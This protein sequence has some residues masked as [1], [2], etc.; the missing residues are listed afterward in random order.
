[1]TADRKMA[2]AFAFRAGG[3]D[4]VSRRAA[5]LDRHFMHAPGV[6]RDRHL[7]VNNGKTRR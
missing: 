7:P 3:R 5:S 4:P 1:M 6:R 2:P